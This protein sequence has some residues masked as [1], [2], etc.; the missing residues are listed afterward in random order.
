MLLGVSVSAKM[1]ARAAAAARPLRP[2]STW[3]MYGGDEDDDEP[4]SGG[5]TT[6]GAMALCSAVALLFLY[7]TMQPESS[8]LPAAP[9]ERGWMVIMVIH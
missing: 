9:T 3:S 2:S 8:E 6:C 5:C 7:A 1:D 4:R